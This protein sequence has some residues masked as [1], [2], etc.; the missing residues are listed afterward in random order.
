MAAHPRPPPL[1]A[2]DHARGDR[3][4]R[5]PSRAPA[6]RPARGARLRP[7]VDEASG[8]PRA[9]AGA[10]APPRAT[11]PQARRSHTLDIVLRYVAAPSRRAVPAFGCGAPF[12]TAEK[13]PL[14]PTFSDRRRSVTCA[15]FTLRGG[16]IAFA[17]AVPQVRSSLECRNGTAPMRRR[18]GQPADLRSTPTRVA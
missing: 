14:R 9:P 17:V 5:R 13:P 15:A 12:V 7:G 3:G 2:A 16:F 11:R 18:A 6:A 8:E 4:A 1:S 10:A